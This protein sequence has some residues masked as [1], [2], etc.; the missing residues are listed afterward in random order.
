MKKSYKNITVTILGGDNRMRCLAQILASKGYQVND[1]DGAEE[2]SDFNCNYLILPLP[3]TQDGI[4]LNC[5]WD[6][7]P[8]LVDIISEVPCNT[9][10][11]AGCVSERVEDILQQ[12]GIEWKDYYT[13]ET[14][15]KQNA[16]LTAE[17]TLQLVMQNTS[18]AVKNS[19]VL[20][21]GS[22]RCG[23]QTAKLFKK[24]GAKVTLTS[25]KLKDKIKT[26]LIG[27]KPAKTARLQRIVNEFQ[28]I[29]NTVPHPVLTERVLQS[30]PEGTFVVEL[31]SSAAGVDLKASEKLGTNLLYAPGLPGRYLHLSAAEA[32]SNTIIKIIREDFL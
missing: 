19:K 30:I 26:L 4:H 31:A 6:N 21:I 27:I 11:L 2:T 17:A 1:I 9:K 3:L 20:V 5:Q 25:R 28:V 10:V 13:K 29:I 14:L 24:I 16:Y 22:G 12:R 23:K 15:Q 32:I 8:K 7:K 18:R